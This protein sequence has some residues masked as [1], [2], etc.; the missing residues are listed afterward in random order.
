MKLRARNKTDDW[1][2]PPELVQSL[3]RF[4]LD[5]CACRFQSRPLADQQYLL[6][7]QNG[8][9]LP[10]VGRVWCNPPFSEL[11]PWIRRFLAHGNGILICPART[12]TLWFW[13]AWKHAD[14]ILFMKGRTRWIP[15]DGL[16]KFGSF[17]QSD[18]LIACG[19]DNVEALRKSGL[20][21][22]LVTQRELFPLTRDSPRAM[23]ATVQEEQ[24]G[25]Q[26]KA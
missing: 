3:G 21:G 18:A 8:L 2:T 10:W 19:L 5:P 4:D 6:P 16:T 1:M 7:E 13:E 9:L 11:N 25:I 17:F 14:G 26:G 20:A 12:E 22:T 15:A 23:M 24:D